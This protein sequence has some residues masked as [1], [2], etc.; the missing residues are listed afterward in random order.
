MTNPTLF[1]IEIE[2][3]D[4]LLNKKYKERHWKKLTGNSISYATMVEKEVIEAF[5]A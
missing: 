2:Y 5:L 4:Y 1:A 3:E